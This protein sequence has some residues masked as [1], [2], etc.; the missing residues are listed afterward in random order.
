MLFL[1]HYFKKNLKEENIHW[2]KPDHFHMTLKFLGKTP[3][4]QIEEISRVLRALSKEFSCFE[5]RVDGAGL[6]GSQ[7]KPKVIWLGLQPKDLLLH[8]H[9]KII[10]SLAS[11]GI[12]S[13]RQNFVPHLSMARIRKINHPAHF[14]MVMEK[15]E[16]GFIQSQKIDK[17]LL[18]ESRLLPRGAEYEIIEG[19]PLSS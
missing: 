8:L 11:L 18:Y 15:A 4:S 2:I 5:M 10:T 14:K 12:E 19:F 17:I 16:Q 9:E 6:F 13:D 3:I 7:Y 1:I